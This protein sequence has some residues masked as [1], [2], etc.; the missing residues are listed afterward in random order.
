[1]KR[2]KSVHKDRPIVTAEAQPV[3]V[4]TIPSQRGGRLRRTRVLNVWMPMVTMKKNEAYSPICL[5]DPKQRQRSITCERLSDD[6][7]LYLERCKMSL[8]YETSQ[9]TINDQS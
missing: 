9:V 5:N 4:T 8:R 3:A 1:M 6:R 7:A 2:Y